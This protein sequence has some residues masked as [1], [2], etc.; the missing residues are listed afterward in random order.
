MNSVMKSVPWSRTAQTTTVMNFE[1]IRPKARR[2]IGWDGRW[3]VT[4]FFVFALTSSAASAGAAELL[5]AAAASSRQPMTEIASRYHDA[6]PDT[7]VVMSF[8]ASSLLARQIRAGAPIDVF[9]SADAQLPADQ[10]GDCAQPSRRDR[11]RAV[12]IRDRRPQYLAHAELL[13]LAIPELAVPVGRYAREW[14]EAVDLFEQVS[15]RILKTDHALATLRAVDAGCADAAIV[16][17]TDGRLAK[18]DLECWRTP[19][20]KGECERD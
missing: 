11:R 3:T 16:Y 4:V 12:R 20:R 14:L 19:G 13:R 9:V 18:S 1:A 7:H 8:G 17:A 5:V 15:D 2:W 10:H 6:Y